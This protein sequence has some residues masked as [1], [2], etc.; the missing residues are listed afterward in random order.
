MVQQKN[1]GYTG[2]LHV[3]VLASIILYLAPN[4]ALAS[5]EWV[6]RLNKGTKV[7]LKKGDEIDNR[8]FDYSLQYTGKYK[9]KLGANKVYDEE[10]PAELNVDVVTGA[11]CECLHNATMRINFKLKK[12][13]I[14][15]PSKCKDKNLNS[16]NITIKKK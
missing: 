11:K 7:T 2:G 9:C 3:F 16:Q 4:L 15:N 6:G 1:A 10:N 12:L 14:E 5:D 8:H 13:S